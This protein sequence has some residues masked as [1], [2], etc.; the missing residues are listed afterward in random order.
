MFSELSA[1]TPQ[2]YSGLHSSRNHK[3]SI[4]RD[5]VVSLCWGSLLPSICKK[6]DICGKSC[7][8][9][10]GQ[11]SEVCPHRAQIREL[12]FYCLVT[13]KKG[14]GV[15]QGGEH[16]EEEAGPGEAVGSGKCL[17]VGSLSC[18]GAHTAQPIHSG[19]EH[20]F[21]GALLEAG[22]ELDA[23]KTKKIGHMVPALEL[24]SV[25]WE[26]VGR[27]LNQHLSHCLGHT[28]IWHS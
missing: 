26:A 4:T 12:L 6:C 7:H 18:C 15:S 19:L 25:L 2:S 14:E 8:V 9:R 11:H 17:G 5:W 22:V 16:R 27:H 13:T 1:G 21:P 20:P 28:Y 24:F 3:V 10:E 23:R